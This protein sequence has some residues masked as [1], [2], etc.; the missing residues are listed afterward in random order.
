VLIC[1][2][3]GLERTRTSDFAKPTPATNI[4]GCG[5]RICANLCDDG[6]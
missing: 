2:R 3:G 6:T 4:T 1:T 5:A